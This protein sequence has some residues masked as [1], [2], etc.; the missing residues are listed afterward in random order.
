MIYGPKTV[1]LAVPAFTIKTVQKSRKSPDFPNMS[2]KNSKFNFEEALQSLEHLVEAMEAGDL[3][4][5]ESLKAFEQGIKLTRECQQ[6][7]ET[8]EQ[9][10][11]V[12]LA[13]TGVPE[14]APFADDEDSDNPG[15]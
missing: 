4:L 3:S 8:A 9:K 1:Q 6:M 7:L 11:Q 5:E 12:L 2:R 14:A 13:N 10:V 15:A